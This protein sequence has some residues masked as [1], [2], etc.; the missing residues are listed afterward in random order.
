MLDSPGGNSTGTEAT[1]SGNECTHCI[2]EQDSNVS[3]ILT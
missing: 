2:A 3:V 1:T